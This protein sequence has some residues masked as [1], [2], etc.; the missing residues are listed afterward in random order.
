MGQKILLRLRPHHTPESFLEIEE[1]VQ[2]IS[3][4]GLQD[5]YDKLVRSGYAG[6]G[7]YSNGH[8]LG[9]AISHNVP[10]HM[11]RAKA[12][13]A[14]EK[15]RRMQQA[16]GDGGGRRLGGSLPVRPGMSQRELSA[17]AAERRARDEK[18]CGQGA[19]AEEEAAKA[20]KESVIDLTGDSDSDDEVMVIADDPPVA[21]GSSSKVKA[22]PPETR[23]DNAKEA[24]GSLKRKAPPER[25]QKVSVPKTDEWECS[26]CTLLNRAGALQCDACLTTRPVDSTF[27]WACL[28][29]GEGGMS[30]DFWTC[31]FCGTMKTTS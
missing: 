18:M 6:E 5:E 11:A 22:K 28:T 19:R 1:V 30:P 2:T 23:R 7:F 12:L 29:C 21:S 10:A 20:A 27:G 24:A 16:L 26:V 15:R 3:L 9:E 25:I 31:S 13:E 17:M 14:A 8:R 4:S